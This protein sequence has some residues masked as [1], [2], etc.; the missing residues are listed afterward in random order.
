M[1]RLVVAL[2]FISLV[3]LRLVTGQTPVLPEGTRV[4][5]TIPTIDY[6]EYRDSE[7]VVRRGEWEVKIKGYTPFIPGEVIEVEGV[8][9][10]Y[11]RVK[12]EGVSVA[13]DMGT[14]GLS[15]L[16]S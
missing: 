6:P 13:T 9:D 15:D 14:R 7:T 16:V 4:R 12:S 1:R 3:L 5:L 11:G 8:I 10:E 2:V